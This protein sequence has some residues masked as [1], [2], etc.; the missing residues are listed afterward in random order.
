MIYKLHVG[1]NSHKTKTVAKVKNVQYIQYNLGWLISVFSLS[2]VTESSVVQFEERN[3]SFSSEVHTETLPHG[4]EHLMSWAKRQY[5]AI[6]SFTELKMTHDVY[7]KVGEGV[8]TC[9]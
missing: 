8:Y 7:V 5:R 4:N 6:T 9:V 1:I 3:L 2:Q